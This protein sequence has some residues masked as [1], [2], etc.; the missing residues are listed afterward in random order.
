[1]LKFLVGVVVGVFLGVLVVAPNPQWSEEV[2]EFWVDAKAWGS[3]FL[4]AAEEA[5]EGVAD[6]AGQAANEIQ[7]RAGEA[8]DEIEQRAGEAARE[9]EEATR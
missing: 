2:Q 4:G 3:A 1:M 9:A 6:E 5:A 7:E 8:A